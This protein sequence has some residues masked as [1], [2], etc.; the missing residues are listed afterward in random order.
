MSETGHKDFLHYDVMVEEALRAVVR[1]ALAR[2]AKHG[3]PGKHHFY[4]SF[5]TDWPEVVMPDHLREKHP[6][7][8]TIV[9]QHQFYNMVVGDEG[10]AVTLSFGGKHEELSVP[11]GAITAFADPSVKFAL[12]FQ[13]RPAPQ[14]VGTKAPRG[15]A[16]PKSEKS[17][18]PEKS[19]EVISLD[20][21]R[22][23]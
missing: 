2:V 7:E 20:Q 18:K 1:E 23:K 14:V 22:R 6:Q 15:A 9:L 12:Q 13:V 17:A 5:R 10:F 4:M 11:F 21:F 19:G 8:M 3:L 16:K